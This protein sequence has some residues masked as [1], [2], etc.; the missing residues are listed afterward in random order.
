MIPVLLIL[1]FL[2]VLDALVLLG[3]SH[4]SRDGRDWKPR[5]SSW[6]DRSAG[7]LS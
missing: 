3:R 6:P 4:D 7:S 2:L 1:T 5:A